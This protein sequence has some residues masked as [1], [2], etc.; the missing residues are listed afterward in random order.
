MKKVNRQTHK[1][2]AADQA[3]G[4]L[5]TKIA[6]LL[7]GKNKASYAPNFDNGDFV[8][9]INVNKLKFTGKK[10][11]QKKYYSYSGYPGGLKVK[12]MS[13]LLE[14]HPEQ[15]LSKAVYNMLPKNKLRKEFMKRLKIA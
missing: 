3:A 14:K 9:V 12:K 6:C 8:E 7:M 10:L 4:R 13:D 11:T 15:I 5:A 1:I 2:D